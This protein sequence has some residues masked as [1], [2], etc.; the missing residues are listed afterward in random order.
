MT[1]ESKCRSASGTR[2]KDAEEKRAVEAKET[3]KLWRLVKAAVRVVDASRSVSRGVYEIA[4][5]AMIAL[6]HLCDEMRFPLKMH[7][8]EIMKASKEGDDE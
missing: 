7:Q 2:F 3:A 4:P 6:R 1:N 8:L 5:E